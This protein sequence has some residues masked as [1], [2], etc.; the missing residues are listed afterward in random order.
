[1]TLAQTGCSNTTA[2]G[3]AAFSS[4]VSGAGSNSVFIGYQCAL[5]WTSSSQCTL[6]G[7]SAGQTG[8]GGGANSTGVGFACLALLT[9]GQQ[10]NA[11]GAGSLSNLTTGNGNCAWGY[12]AGQN[13]T[14]SES[15]NVLINNLGT[16]GESNVCRIGAST[17]TGSFQLNSTFIHGINGVT[18]SNPLMV[19]INSSTSQ[20]GVAAVPVTSTAW[21]VITA[22]QTAAVNNGYICNKAG[23]LALALPATAAI[24]SIIEVTGINT[25]LGWQITQATGQQIFFG[26]S[27]T[28]S[29]ATGTITSSATRDSIKMVC[30]VANTTWNIISSIGSPTIV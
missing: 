3:N 11:F 15:Y 18:S 8:V 2:I 4:Y 21:S 30:V 22:N 1:M 10:N 17:G 16:V 19:T 12:Q 28:T 23:T 6:I 14:S 13:Y 5:S 25:A 26:T 9:S 24:G 27:S 20:L 7:A 29:G